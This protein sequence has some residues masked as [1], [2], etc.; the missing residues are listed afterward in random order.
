MTTNRKFAIAILAAG[1]GTRLKSKHP[2]VLHEIAGKPLLDHVVAAAAKVVPPSQIFAIIGHEADRVREAMQASGIQFVEQKEQR[3]TGHAIL[4]TRDALKDFDDV[5]VLSGDVPLIRTDTVERLFAFHREH[6]AAMTILTTEPPDP[7]GYGRV[8]RKHAGQSDE[9]DRI[10]EQKQLTPEQA[11]NREINSGIYA[12]RVQPLFA[13]LDKLTTDNPHGEY[14]LTDM[15]AILGGASEKVVAIRADD[16]HEVLGVNTRQDLASLDAHLRLQKCQQLMSAGV[17]IFKPETCMIDSDVEVGPDT[18]IEPFVQLLGNT[19]IGA[20]CHIKSYTVIS[21]STIGD[22]V[23]LRHGCI[24]DSSKVAARALLGPYCHL[25]PASDIGE[26]AH[27]G[28]FVETKKTRVG[29]GSKA[30]H[31]TYLGDTEIGTGVNIG[32][33]TITCNYDGV[34]KFGT[35]IGDNVF[36]GSDTTLV[37]PIELGKGSYIGAG[38][39]ITENVPDDALAIGRGRQV[40]KEGWATKKRA[41]QKKKK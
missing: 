6:A 16:S 13:N 37:A 18:I 27:I 39:C 2:K 10:V 40:V 33:G 30:N 8:F 11:R 15:A 24:V 32:A 31:L 35:I 36:V 20:D 3:G 4:Q 1:K 41:E 34:N 23:L 19:K 5:L 9:V 14:Y 7:F 21:N 28:N 25:R 17:S 26:E 12:F 29:K 22:G 38:S